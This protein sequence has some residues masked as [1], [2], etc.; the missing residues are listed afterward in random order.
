MDWSSSWWSAS[1]SSVDTRPSLCSDRLRMSCSVMLR[2]VGSDSAIV[3]IL[4]LSGG[5]GGGGGRN[6]GDDAHG[7]ARAAEQ[8]A[9]GS[10]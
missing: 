9:G 2:F 8:A 3:V 7:A 4:V 1:S 6:G 5:R 10:Q